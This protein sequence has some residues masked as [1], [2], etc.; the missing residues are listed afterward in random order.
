MLLHTPGKISSKPPNDILCFHG[1]STDFWRVS[2]IDIGYPHCVYT[3]HT[4]KLL[5]CWLRIFGTSMGLAL[6]YGP[7]HATFKSTPGRF[8]AHQ[9]HSYLCSRGLTPTA[10]FK[11]LELFWVY[12]FRE[13]LPHRAPC[14]QACGLQ[15][16]NP[17]RNGI[18]TSIMNEENL[19]H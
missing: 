4:S 14:Y 18:Q 5:M 12:V 15:Y 16:N 6:T 9:S 19:L 10:A 17:Q 8:V 7:S 2:C 13:T 1:V 3:L 11:Q